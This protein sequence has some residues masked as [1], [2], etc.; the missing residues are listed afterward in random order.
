MT[1]YGFVSDLSKRIKIKSLP[2]FLFI[3]VKST[4]SFS[5]HFIGGK[6]IDEQ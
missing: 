2:F 6:D 3:C 1:F 4:H 5:L